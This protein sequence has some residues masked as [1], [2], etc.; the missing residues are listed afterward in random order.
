MQFRILGPLEVE[1]DGKR[2][3]VG[4]A[5]QRALLAS[6]LLRAN[7]PVSRDTLI[8]QLW[9]ERAP[10]SAAHRLEEHVSRLRKTLYRNGEVLLVSQPGAYMLRVEEEG[11]DVKR[12]GQLVALGRGAL[13]D[14]NAAEAAARLR[15]GLALWRGWPLN[16]VY[17]DAVTWP[18]LGELEEQRASAQEL[19]MEAELACGRHAEII[20]ELDALTRG[21]P[22]RERL[23]FLLMLAL[24]RSGRQAQAL[25][26]YQEAR[27]LLDEELGIEPGPALKHLQQAILRQDAR[28]DLFDADG[29]V[30]PPLTRGPPGNLIRPATS[31]VGREREIGEILTLI[32]NGGRLVTLT[33]PG[34]S[35]KTRLAL[36]AAHRVVAEFPDGAFWVDLAALRDS[37]LVME[38]IARRL[39]AREGIAAHVGDRRV[40]LV[41]DN[42]EHV[43]RAA[44]ELASLVRECP[45][46]HVLVTSRQLPRVREVTEYE[47]LPLAES[48]A[49]ELFC[50]RSR[51]RPDDNVAELCRRLDN[52]PLG[53]EFAAAR[54]A[55]LSLAEILERISQRLD[56]L[57]G[58]RD[59]EARQK[60]LRATI[61]WSHDLLSS[62]EQELFAQLAVFAGGCTLEAAEAVAGAD[63]DTLQSLV[64]KSLV[65][66]AD[67]RF[68]ML[69]TTREF[70]VEG[71]EQSGKAEDL[72]N[73]HLSYFTELAEEVEPR[74]WTPDA[75]RS[76]AALLTEL[77]NFRASLT[78]ARRSRTLIRL[79]AGLA[80]LF[81]VANGIHEEGRSWLEEALAI[82]DC[83]AQTR[84]RAHFGLILI[85]ELEGEHEAGR[86]HASTMLALAQ[87]CDDPDGIF[88]ALMNMGVLADDLGDS[89]AF[90]EESARVA[91][92]A[93]NE[94]LLG[95][96]R[97]NLGTRYL[98]AGSYEQA[99]RCSDEAL[100]LWSP[101]SLPI[102]RAATLT[103]AGFAA[104]ELG[105]L[106]IATQRLGQS[107]R[108]AN[109]LGV[110]IIGQLEAFAALEIAKGRIERAARLTGASQALVDQGFL[111]WEPFQRSVHK[112]TV[113]A[114]EK[115]LDDERLGATLAEGRDMRRDEAVA[116]AL[117][118]APV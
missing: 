66:H 44:P 40:L 97:A 68:W 38:T 116:Y 81:W 111:L 6:L 74:L 11:L 98:A 89:E 101:G 73:R 27:R 114:L 110:A 33:G 77:D 103:I 118:S 106:D 41:V 14:G 112:Q 91:R 39:G 67:G 23:R 105:Q 113:A 10:G 70:A 94:Q 48:E 53:I 84:M 51:A 52:L 88:F 64:E 76:N 79:A 95:F 3:I 20:D 78:H 58:T 109:E 108:L 57:E 4:G 22:L 29:R 16:D 30:L 55:V 31:L 26:S 28:L 102:I 25:D 61:E 49:I 8:D 15:E 17:S 99:L 54:M 83:P 60:T 100:E 1:V 117:E 90:F 65:Q 42:F 72:R 35:G 86:R 47:V 93:K 7:E 21:D 80:P 56:L 63:L 46:L 5:K 59:A 13:Q 43:I 12:F 87:E 32:E 19:L 85:A 36:E 75:A 18:E 45:N 82:P 9:G 107:L 34:G 62:E 69:E 71:L 37:A 2:L 115:A 96:V 50:R 104:R 24:Y 92:A